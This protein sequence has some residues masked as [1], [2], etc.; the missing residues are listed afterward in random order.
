MPLL[1]PAA[2]PVT[3]RERQQLESLERQATCPQQLALRARIILLASQGVGVR[4]T[5]DQLGISR[6]TVQGWRRRWS[7]NPDASVAERLSDAP[8]SGTPATFSPEQI[9][10][11]I[12]L[13]CE[14]PQD[15]GRAVT[16]RKI[17]DEA[18]KRGIVGSISARSIGRFLKEAEL[19]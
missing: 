2:V 10:A 9:C 7:E 3:D 18:V 13:V 14:A 6:S 5:A 16:Q 17:A 1:C 12:A 4:P 19:R 11:I 8:R 15:S